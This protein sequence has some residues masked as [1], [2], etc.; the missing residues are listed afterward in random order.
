MPIVVAADE[1]CNLAIIFVT[2]VEIASNQTDTMTRN[3][4]AIPAAGEC[5][6]LHLELYY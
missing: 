4:F 3:Y 1:Y 6:N 2:A 5:D